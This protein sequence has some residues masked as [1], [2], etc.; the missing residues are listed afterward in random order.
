MDKEKLVSLLSSDGLLSQKI[1]Q[2]EVR[3]SQQEMLADVIEAYEEQKI[4]LIEAGTGTG[5]SLAY[6]LP[7]IIW[8]LEKNEP[9]VIAT[10][11]IA[12]QEQLIEKDIP[13][14]LRSLD[15]DLKAVL[16][17]GM[18]NY[19]CL[20]KLH[21]TATELPEALLSWS[22]TTQE[23]SRSELPLAPSRELWEEIGA[24]ADSC[25]HKR[26]PH[27]KE[28]FFFKARRQLADAHLIVA[29]HHL[30]FADLSIRQESDNY[31]EMCLLPS[32]NRL[33]LDEAHHIEDVATE[34]FADKVSTRGL[35][36][37]LGRLFSEKKVGKIPF[38]G[39]KILE[40]YP[41][42][43]RRQ[44]V[45][46]IL[47]RIES[48]LPLERR[49]LND[50]IHETFEIIGQ[51]H[52]AHRKEEKLRLREGHFSE[53]FWIEEVQPATQELVEMGKRFVQSL[54]LLEP[55]IKLI[56]E[57]LLTEKCE[58][59]LIEIGAICRRLQIFFKNLHNFIFSPLEASRVRWMEG[60]GFN[61][62]LVAADLEVASRLS[63]TMF[64]RMGTVILCSATLTANTNFKFVRK[65]LG[66]E[67]AIEKIYESPFLYEKQAM[68]LVPTDLPDP[69]HL[70]FTT[71][72]AERIWEAIEGSRGG[73]F[74]LFTSYAML[75]EC[76]SILKD[77]LMSKRYSLYCQGEEARGILL[78][79]FRTSQKA[80]LFGTDSFWEG[81][82]VVGE[83]LRCVVLVKLPFKVPSDPL[84]QA[85]SEAITSDGGSAFFDYSLP[86]AIVKFKQGFGRLI[87]AKEDRGCVICL[88]PRLVNKGYG[89]KF[90]KS[91]PSCPHRF[92]KDEE[93]AKTIR[94]FFLYP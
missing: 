23:G 46:T 70:S 12:L 3:H 52:Q 45:S 49:N 1:P 75:Q 48:L 79:K 38:L 39:K 26:C 69:S 74:V 90:L 77:R 84:F 27:Y 37:F 57:D 63:E 18:H 94:Q 13:F 31:S 6:L 62:Q 65:R 24:E 10:H 7:A 4:A 56:K 41:K 44:D 20:R 91:L 35:L 14:L 58:T 72:A 67:E 33:V 16:A 11:T 9:T 71:H 86:H 25:T 66:I 22:Q 5:K 92:E 78:G 87:R 80:V 29:N 83:A 64:Q 93:Y 47:H 15:L 88:D 43:E 59:I 54:L 32:Y 21:D 28:C 17:K 34:H 51:F 30:L 40:V 19:V 50:K 61:F 42:N 82:D 60:E 68:L 55:Q 36:H 76:R 81:I 53:T 85:R 89:K 2:F 8:A 73:I